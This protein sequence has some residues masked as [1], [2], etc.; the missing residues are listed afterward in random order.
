[1]RGPTIVLVA[2]ATRETLLTV[3][4]TVADPGGPGAPNPRCV[5]DLRLD[6]VAVPAGVE[7]SEAIRSAFAE[8]GWAED[9][10]AAADGYVILDAG[11]S[12]AD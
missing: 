12:A 1:M 7:P 5:V 6:V 4:E 3:P 9:V 10:G 2:A 8:S 11:C